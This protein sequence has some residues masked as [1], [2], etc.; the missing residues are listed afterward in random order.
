VSGDVPAL[1]TPMKSMNISFT[2]TIVGFKTSYSA[3]NCA[4]TVTLDFVGMVGVNAEYVAVHVVGYTIIPSYS[5]RPK[6]CDTPHA[7]CKY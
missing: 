1:G 3:I 7:T 6:V 5:S 2:S 4:G